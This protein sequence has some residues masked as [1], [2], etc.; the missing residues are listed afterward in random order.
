MAAKAATDLQE[1]LHDIET[2]IEN[3]KEGIWT[4]EELE[5]LISKVTASVAINSS[6]PVD[7]DG[8]KRLQTIVGG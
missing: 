3:M 6:R 1:R 7:R 8:D 5:E 4:K 2:D